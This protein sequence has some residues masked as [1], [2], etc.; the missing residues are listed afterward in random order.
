MIRSPCWI[1]TTRPVSAKRLPAWHEL[2]RSHCQ[3][4]QV[5]RQTIQQSQQKL[6]TFRRRRTDIAQRDALIAKFFRSRLPTIVKVDPHPDDEPWR[7]GIP[8]RRNLDE[9]SGDFPLFQPDIVR[10]FEADA[11][12][13]SD[14]GKASTTT[15]PRRWPPEARSPGGDRAVPAQ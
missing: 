11:N 4:L 8:G 12:L 6:S 2:L 3:L 7:D 10:P 15:T 14:L 1:C 9:N 13:R 5:R